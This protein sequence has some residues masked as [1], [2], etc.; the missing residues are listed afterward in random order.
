MN[1]VSE[2]FIADTPKT[3]AGKF[4]LVHR[5]LMAGSKD[6]SCPWAHGVYASIGSLCDTL[7]SRVSL[8]AIHAH[9]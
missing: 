9:A 6:A 4:L 5:I 7:L 8:Y 1:H 2:T 3:G